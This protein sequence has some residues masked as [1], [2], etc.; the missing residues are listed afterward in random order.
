MEAAESH[1]GM[2]DS[3]GNEQTTV[4]HTHTAQHHTGRAAEETDTYAK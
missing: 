2:P 1:K 4:T 3:E